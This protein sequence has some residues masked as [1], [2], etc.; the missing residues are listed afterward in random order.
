MAR[1]RRTPDR[2]PTPEQM[3]VMELSGGPARVLAGAG[4]G[5]TAT[6]TRLVER[7]VYEHGKWG[8]GTAPERILALTFTVKAAEEMRS[9]LLG[10]L[11][12]AALGLTVANFHSHALEMVRENAAALSVD[13]EAPVLRQGRAWLM[14]LD[15]FASDDLSLNRLDLSSPATAADRALKLLSAAKNDLVDL[16]E[17]RRRTE[18]DLANPDATGE[19]RRCFEER[20][21][22]IELARR[23]EARREERGLLRYEDMISLAARALAHPEMGAPYRGRYDLIVVDEFQDT[24]PAQLRLVELLA[25]GDLS[26]VVVIGDDLQSIYNFTGASIR[27][28][29]T[30]EERA[31][32][33]TGSRTFPLSTNFRSGEGILALA[34]HIAKG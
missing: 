13:A 24:N 2:K 23:F 17:L 20:L 12:N 3:R 4:S 5:K 10:T 28:I 26:K 7:H 27:N 22:L 29:Q 9:R 25:D 18:E 31:G 15:D 8:A 1:V 30:F 6:M 34:N 33:Q 16:S 19:M 11:G 32:V 21:D 14:I